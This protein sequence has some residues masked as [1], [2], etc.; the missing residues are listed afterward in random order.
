M[1]KDRVMCS[2]EKTCGC[3][4]QPKKRQGTD[5]V[6]VGEPVINKS[7]NNCARFIT[8]HSDTKY[9]ALIR[10]RVHIIV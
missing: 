10:E 6:L 4:H 2:G 7:M 5:F 3:W 8:G 9:C 1:A